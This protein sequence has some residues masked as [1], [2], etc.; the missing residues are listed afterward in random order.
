MNQAAV[1]KTYPPITL[2][3]DPGRVARFTEVVDADGV[4]GV[5]PTFVTGGEFATFPQIVDDPDLGLDFS[6]VLHG[7]Q[8]YEWRRALVPGETLT[9]TAHVSQIRQRG[10]LGFCTI[11]SEIRDEGGALVVLA[12]CTFLE[13]GNEPDPGGR[14]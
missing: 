8:Q 4:P 5:P 13:R 10:P 7:E 3:V 2:V 1:G 12:R 14:P 6:K 11:E 9:V